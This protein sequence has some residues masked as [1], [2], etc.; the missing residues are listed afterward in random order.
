MIWLDNARIVAIFA[1][2]LLHVAASVL[3]Q[4]E[5]GS[6][7]CWIGNLYDS[8]VRWC[9]PLFLMISGAL[10]LDPKKDENLKSF[11]LK[12]A[13]RIF[14]PTVFW[15][16]FFIIFSNINTILS[17]G[18]LVIFDLLQGILSGKPHYPIW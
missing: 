13:S 16:F 12:R 6:E 4:S 1:V 7:N 8:F 18:P 5:V 3:T 2:V 17:S 15:S 10:L 11:Y 14:V 9:V